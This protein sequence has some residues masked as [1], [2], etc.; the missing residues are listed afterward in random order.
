MK[1]YIIILVILLS[2]CASQNN[3]TSQN[4]PSYTPPEERPAKPA[5]PV[6]T[7][8]QQVQETK[9][10]PTPAEKSKQAE[11]KKA[12]PAPKP[13][14][15]KKT[16]EEV[17]KNNY[18]CDFK[19]IYRAHSAESTTA[20]EGQLKLNIKEDILTIE[21]IAP[22]IRGTYKLKIRSKSG[23]S[24]IATNKGMVFHYTFYPQNFTFHTGISAAKF[25]LAKGGHQGNQMR[26]S[27][28]CR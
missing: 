10:E 4:L 17:Y 3:K 12:K 8:K 11:V 14:K 2:G 1:Y 18:V 13:A 9:P 16:P 5:P 22:Q 19:S 25:D 23:M 24:M 28:K 6:E 26:V 20:K 15:R 7:A 27:G 21:V